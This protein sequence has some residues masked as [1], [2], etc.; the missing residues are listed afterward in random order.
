MALPK[1]LTFNRKAC[2]L[3]STRGLE[4][5]ILRLR[6]EVNHA[7]AAFGLGT[8]E[9]TGT[10]SAIRRSKTGLNIKM[11]IFLAP[12][13]PTLAEFA[14]GTGDDLSLPINHKAAD[15]APLTCQSLPTSTSSG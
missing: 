8:V 10:G 4:R 15:I 7:D 1:T 12:E 9:A 3:P 13:L 5:F 6:S 2:L 11:T 14:L